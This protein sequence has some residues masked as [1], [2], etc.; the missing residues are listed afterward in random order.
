MESCFC[1][2]GQSGFEA[3]DGVGVPSRGENYLMIG[4]PL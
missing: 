2:M 4:H 1:Y 3:G